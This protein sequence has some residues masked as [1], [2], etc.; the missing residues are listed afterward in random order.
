MT[1][2]RRAALV[3]V[4]VQ[5][6]FCEGGAMGVDGGAAVAANNG[7]PGFG[8]TRALDLVSRH[9]ILEADDDRGQ[10]AAK[11]NELRVLGTT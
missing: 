7:D 6:D 5:N 4:D 9:A 10:L 8:P 1:T 11:A 3:V 2:T